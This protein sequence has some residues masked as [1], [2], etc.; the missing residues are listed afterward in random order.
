MIL[1]INVNDNNQPA[2]Y[3]DRHPKGYF[4]ARFAGNHLLI[5]HYLSNAG[6]LQNWGMCDP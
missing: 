5:D 2:T 3:Y 1:I 4:L 6:V